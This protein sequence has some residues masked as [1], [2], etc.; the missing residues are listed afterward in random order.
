MLKALFPGVEHIQNIHPLFVHFPIAF[1]VAA[2]LFYFLAW[3]PGRESL[4][5]TAFLL[6]VLGALAA[7]LAAGT[8]LYAEDGVM[9]SRSV[10]AN[11]LVP[12]KRY[13]LATTALGFVLAGW[14]VSDR[15]FPQKGRAFFLFLLLVLL[16]IMSLGGDFGVR[17]VY[18]YNAGGNACPQPIE[19]AR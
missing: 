7:A 13:M 17:M 9:V 19:F 2:S 10:K 8:G 6:L 18:D 1:L 3:R 15:P 11:L 5:T 12:H 4:A 14:A 16:A